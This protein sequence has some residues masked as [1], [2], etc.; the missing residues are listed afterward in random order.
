MAEAQFRRALQISLVM[1]SCSSSTPCPPPCWS[2]PPW[3]SWRVRVQGTS[4]FQS[5]GRV[6]ARRHGMR[7]GG[8]WS[9]IIARCSPRTGVAIATWSADTAHCHQASWRRCSGS[10][11]R[12]GCR[13]RLEICLSFRPWTTPSLPPSPS[14]PCPGRFRLADPH[15]PGRMA[16]AWRIDRQPGDLRLHR[17]NYTTMSRVAGSSRTGRNACL[18][19][20]R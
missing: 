16:A 18:S 14:G 10:V 13:W 8:R 9:S 6:I 3:P 19:T 17:R 20:L 5:R 15:S 12:L 7:A 4:A 2:S 11:D 1:G